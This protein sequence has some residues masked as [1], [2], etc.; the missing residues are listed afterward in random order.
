[1]DETSRTFRRNVA[2]VIGEVPIFAHLTAHEHLQLV[3]T[4][5]GVPDPFEAAK[6]ALTSIFRAVRVPA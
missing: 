1:M 3:A 5:H 6:Q 4:G 2:A